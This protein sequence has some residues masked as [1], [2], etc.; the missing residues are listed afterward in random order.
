MK[1]FYS[2][3]SLCLIV[4]TLLFSENSFEK[5]CR[6]HREAAATGIKNHDQLIKESDVG[7][8]GSNFQIVYLS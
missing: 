3:L 8:L 2:L 5:N 1:T 6:E 7:V 4:P